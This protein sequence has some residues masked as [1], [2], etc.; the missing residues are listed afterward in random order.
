MYFKFIEKIKAAFGCFNGSLLHG[1]K[2]SRS[3][4]YDTISIL[5]PSFLFLSEMNT[6]NTF[7]ESVKFSH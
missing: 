3:R 4:L 1:P 7:D 6:M 2:D 5:G